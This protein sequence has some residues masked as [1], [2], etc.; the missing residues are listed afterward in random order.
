MAD[1]ESKLLAALRP[2]CPQVFTLDR[3][4]EP[5]SRPGAPPDIS[6]VLKELGQLHGRTSFLWNA[7]DGCRGRHVWHRVAETEIKSESHFWAT[8]NYVLHNAVRHGYVEALAGLALLECR[9][10]SRGSWAGDGRAPL[11]ELSALRLREGLGPAGF[12]I[13]AAG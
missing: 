10:V 13:I 2:H 4:A 6:A 7:E 8:M 11:A 9:R 12:V 3:P 1:F 5:L